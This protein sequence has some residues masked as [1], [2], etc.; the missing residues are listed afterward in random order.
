MNTKAYKTYFPEK[1]PIKVIPE[2]RNPN[3][4]LANQKSK[5]DVQNIS[6]PN[7]KYRIQARSPNPTFKFQIQNLKSPEIENRWSRIT[8]PQTPNPEAPK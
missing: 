5:P 7:F 6:N 8:K 2:F 4:K 1:S 3:S